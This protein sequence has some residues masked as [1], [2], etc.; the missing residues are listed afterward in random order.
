MYD[1]VIKKFFLNKLRP[2]ISE[3]FLNKIF[4]EFV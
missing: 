1:L 3:Y 2:Y 4:S